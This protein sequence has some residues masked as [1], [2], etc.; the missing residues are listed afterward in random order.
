[1]GIQVIREVVFASILLE[2]IQPWLW[3]QAELGDS[4]RDARGIVIKPVGGAVAYHCT[5]EVYLHGW[6]W[7]SAVEDV[8]LQVALVNLPSK[9]WDVKT[10]VALSRNKQRIVGVFRELFVKLLQSNECIF[11]RAHVRVLDVVT[12]IGHDRIPDA[13]WRFNIKNVG[14]IVP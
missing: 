4:R 6:A 9:I 7:S 3:Y 11:R 12:V 1:M 10:S 2:L 13:G 14:L 8:E 5:N